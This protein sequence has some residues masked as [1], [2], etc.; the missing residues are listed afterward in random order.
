[1]TSGNVLKRITLFALPCIVGN[2][3]QNLYN[4]ID[5][6]IVG[7]SDDI[8]ALAAVGATGSL[9]SLFLNTVIGLM[10]GFSVTAGKRC[11]AED[12]KGVK[13][14]FANAMLL[15]LVLGIAVSVLGAIFSRRMLLLMNTPDDILEDAVKY[16]TVIFIGMWSSV[17]YNFLCEML[18]AL[19]NSKMPLVFLFLSSVLHIVLILIF[20]FVFSM[21]VIGAALSTVLSQIFA[22][23]L[24]VIYIR[25]RV[26]SLWLSVSDLTPD[27]SVMRECLRIGIPMAITN[28]VVMFGVIILS[29]VTNGIGEEYVAGYSTASR[30]GY[31]VTTPIFGFATA[32]SVFAAQN[33]GRGDMARIQE[34]VRK[35]FI[36][37]TAINVVLLVVFTFCTVPLL[38]YLLAGDVV[39]VDAGATYL[40]IRCAA[41][42]VLT[43]AAGFKSVLNAL[44]RTVFPTVSGFI[45]IGI[46][47]LIPITLSESLGFLSVP[48]TDA[49]AWFVLAVFLAVGYFVEIKKIKLE[50]ACAE[51]DISCYEKSI[52]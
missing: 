12:E 26:P 14:V 36:L 11:G 6:V 20:L 50:I 2:A 5:S 40:R 8:G 46:R 35:T 47:Y 33:F 38:S 19:G 24:C 13:R 31:I 22:V 52:F 39:A 1:M 44:G 43:F 21:G 9:I 27:L 45:E 28:F 51:G 7:K 15:T 37:V 29:F 23:A 10:T 25:R 4:I 16:L 3:L 34:G 41:M 17:F 49:V 18:R 30:I 42:L 48:L 32:L